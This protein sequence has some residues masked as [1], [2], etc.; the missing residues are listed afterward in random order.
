[1]AGKTMTLTIF[2][3][4]HIRKDWFFDFASMEFELFL[5]EL[6]GDL[7]RFGIKLGRADNCDV[8]I[9]INSYG[10][11]LNAVRISSPVDGFS[12]ICVGHVIGQSPNRDILEDIKRA[13]NRVAFAPETIQPEE[14]NRK[15]CHNCGCG[16]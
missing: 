9:G 15:V 16:C 4:D 2:G 14:S 10:D 1:M 8:V 13:I 7:E 12:S 5:V 11:L 6:T 3:Q